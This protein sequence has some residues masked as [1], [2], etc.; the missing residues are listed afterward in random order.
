LLEWV[1]DYQAILLEKSGWWVT[2]LV[3]LHQ[4]FLIDC[5]LCKAVARVMWVLLGSTES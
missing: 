2:W 1:S 3:A 4:S 5:V